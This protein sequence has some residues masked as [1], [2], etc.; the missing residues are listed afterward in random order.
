MKRQSKFGPYIARRSAHIEAM[1][2]LAIST[3]DASKYGLITDYCRALSAIITELRAAKSASPSSPYFNRKVKPFSHV[4]LMRNTIYREMVEKPFNS[5]RMIVEEQKNNEDEDEDVEE[6]KY[7][8][9]SLMAQTNLLKER[10][11]ALDAGRGLTAIDNAE[12]EKIIDKLNQR[13]EMLIRV[14]QDVLDS[15]N[16]AFRLVLDPTEKQPVAG[17]YGPK[18]LVASLDDLEEIKKAMKEHPVTLSA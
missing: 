9:V 15:V 13:I 3:I 18:G 17:M 7:K 12:A 10:V 16:G 11:I 6:L 5:S 4:T 8:V 2:G 14:N 1:I